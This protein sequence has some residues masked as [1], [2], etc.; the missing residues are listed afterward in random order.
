MRHTVSGFLPSSRVF[1]RRLALLV[2]IGALLPLSSGAEP[3]ASATTRVVRDTAIY[4]RA[5]TLRPQAGS[6][7]PAA[8]SASVP[9][10][11][12]AWFLVQLTSQLTPAWRRQLG[13]LG[14]LGGYIPVNTLMI[15]LEQRR[16]DQ[17]AR[18]HFVR[19]MG[20]LT[21][22]YRM[23]PALWAAT[24]RL[25]ARLAGQRT[26]LLAHGFAGLVLTAAA[27]R[28][29]GVEVLARS[30][31]RLVGDILRIRVRWDRVRALAATTDIAWIEPRGRFRQQSDVV[32]RLVGVDRAWSAFGLYGAGQIVA[33]ADTGLDTGVTTTLGLDVAGRLVGVQTLGRP[34]Q[35]NDPEGHGTH[36]A[37]ILA[38]SGALSGANPATHAY[39]GT[40]AGVAPE[41][42]LYVQSILDPSGTINGIPDNLGDL[43]GPAYQAG[44]RIHNDS[45]GNIPADP[46]NRPAYGAYDAAAQQ[47]DA[48]VWAHPD[49][50]IVLAAGNDGVDLHP[51]DGVVDLGSIN[52]PALAKDVIAVGG[53]ENDRPPHT[54]QGGLTDD[55]WNK[56]LFVN[57]DN[58]PITF[59]QEPIASSYISGNPEGMIPVSSRGPTADGRIKPDLTAPSSNVATVRSVEEPAGGS[60]GAV[61]GR[62]GY[63]YD[64]GTSMAAPV[65]SGAAA[66][67]R[68]YLGRVNPGAPPSA[69]LL[70]ALLLNSAHDMQPGQYGTGPKQEMGAR[71][72]NV[73]G[74]GRVD[75]GAIVAPRAPTNV[76][77]A[78]E[79]TGLTTAQS[80]TY[81]VTITDTSVPLRVTLAWSDYPG[82]LTAA[83]ELVNDLD[84]TVSGPDGSAA[85]N[86]GQGADHA[87]TVETADVLAPRAGLYT[88]T[89]SGYNV[90]QGPQPYALALSCGCGGLLTRGPTV[91]EP[92]IMA[93][94]TTGPV[95]LATTGPLSSVATHLGAWDRATMR[96]RVAAR[97]LLTS[98]QAYQQV[99]RQRIVTRITI[100]GQ[101]GAP[102][103]VLIDF[104]SGLQIR[105]RQVLDR[106]G[107]LQVDVPLPT[108]TK[109]PSTVRSVRVIVGS[110]SAARTYRPTVR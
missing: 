39:S 85:I 52:T 64:G 14:I 76:G 9:A 18:L 86:G 22:R 29:P 91:V 6:F 106:H 17:V 1:P 102:V 99:N 63:V 95:P 71:P 60:W 28:G 19:W 30:P 108:G 72:N 42:S 92:P 31:S 78:E 44:A 77:W 65:V 26:E 75:L 47:T 89:I 67:L 50:L 25:A 79:R 100:Q 51:A 94:A 88:V 34:G 5:A 3:R 90:P 66:L 32:R 57:S 59:T 16:V 80:T 10:S 45:W 15:G 93:T 24:A 68:E 62:P 81:S 69:A 38:G 8:L 11:G 104:A 23:A 98:V 101:A 73:E 53:S 27:V 36:V 40:L 49:M 35:W 82:A 21:P 70:K 61:P 58:V 56:P 43:Y 20:P 87:N 110:G 48:F 33:I 84:L 109:E 97:R 105:V 107:F 13:A 7:Q 12:H 41:A 55:T 46:A 83:R 74:W 96:R 4:L 103:Q 37:G 54:G 2:L